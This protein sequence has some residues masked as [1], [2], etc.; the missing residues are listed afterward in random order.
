MRVF[1][2]NPP[3]LIPGMPSNKFLP[4]LTPIILRSR[5]TADVPERCIP[6][7]KMIL[8]GISQSLKFF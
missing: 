5:V 6:K 2:Q 8:E 7:I 1:S 3:A 4:R